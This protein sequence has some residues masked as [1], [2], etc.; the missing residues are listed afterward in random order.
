MWD[1]E[2]L[3]RTLM[4]ARPASFD[5]ALADLAEPGIQVAV[6]WAGWDEGGLRER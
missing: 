6:A 4:A 3:A 5:T 1:G 2:F